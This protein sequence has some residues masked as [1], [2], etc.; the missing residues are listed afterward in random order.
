MRRRGHQLRSEVS[1]IKAHANK[2][3]TQSKE[4]EKERESPP[5]K[6]EKTTCCGNQDTFGED[7]ATE[8]QLV[9]PWNRSI[10]SGLELLRTP[11]YNKGL[12]F[13]QR[14]RESLFVRL[15]TSGATD[16]GTSG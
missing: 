6:N 13:S 3:E 11:Q 5:E 14:E 10:A 12:A 16:S 9:T 4:R 7:S 2:K 15:A 8:D 1:C